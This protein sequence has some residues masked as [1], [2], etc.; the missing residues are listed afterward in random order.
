[1]LCDNCDNN[2]THFHCLRKAITSAPVG[3]WYCD[4]CCRTLGLPLGTIIS[5]DG[6]E[7]METDDLNETQTK[8]VNTS[9]R[10]RKSVTNTAATNSNKVSRLSTDGTNNKRG[11]PFKEG[12]NNTSSVRPIV[13]DSYDEN[14]HLTHDYQN[15]FIPIRNEDDICY[16][17]QQNGNLI[18]CDYPLCNKSYHQV[19]VFNTLPYNNSLDNSNNNSVTDLWYCPKHFCM[20]CYTLQSTDLVV[21][22]LP[23]NIL[24][25]ISLNKTYKSCSTCSMMICSDCETDIIHTANNTNTTDSSSETANANSIVVSNISH[26]A[27]SIFKSKRGSV[28]KVSQF[29]MI[30]IILTDLFSLCFIRVLNV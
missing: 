10:K 27:D 12:T 24:G 1:M 25:L 18:L 30:C 17:C 14:Y 26:S 6:D 3:K 7:L 16:I 9:G 29:S 19:C 13:L 2:E 28:P 15:D 4:S 22:A 21:D 5:P 11:R 23:S 20:K 8:T